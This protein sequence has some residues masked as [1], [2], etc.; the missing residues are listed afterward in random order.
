MAAD[1]YY[2]IM[3]F[4]AFGLCAYF[5]QTHYKMDYIRIIGRDNLK[6]NWA[7]ALIPA[8]EIIFRSILFPA[9]LSFG[10]SL[11]WIILIMS[12]LFGF[13][14]IPFHSWKIFALTL[15]LGTG[16]SAIYVFFPNFYLVTI[17]HGIVWITAHFFKI[18]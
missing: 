15:V 2:Y 12:F 14:H 17:L 9:L 16:I 10:L 5:K 13:A 4:L 8:Q 3:F 1:G 18:I 11:P 6:S 7:L